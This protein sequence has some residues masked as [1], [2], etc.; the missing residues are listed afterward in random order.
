MIDLVGCFAA[1]W[2]IEGLVTE[3]EKDVSTSIIGPQSAADK[4]E[5]LLTEEEALNKALLLRMSIMVLGMI[6]HTFF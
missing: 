4:E 6:V 3:S 5:A 1:K 2:A